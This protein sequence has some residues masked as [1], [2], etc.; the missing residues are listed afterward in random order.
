MKKSWKNRLVAVVMILVSV[1]FAAF[2][3]EVIAVN[4]LIPEKELK[5]LRTYNDFL[6]KPPYVING[7]A[8]PFISRYEQ[9]DS[10]FFRLKRNYSER[11][12]DKI[13]KYVFEFQTNEEGFRDVSFET[14]EFK[15]SKSV[16]LIGDSVTF[17]HGVNQ[18]D[19]FPW[20]LKDLLPRGWTSLNLGVG[21]W[22]PAEYYLAAREYIGKY[23]PEVVVLSYYTSNDFYDIRNSI[24][25]GKEQGALPESVERVNYYFDWAGNFRPKGVFRYPI[26]RNSKL[27]VWLQRRHERQSYSKDVANEEIDMASRMVNDLTTRFPETRFV[28]L[29]FPRHRTAVGSPMEIDHLIMRFRDRFMGG[30]EP[31]PNLYVRDMFPELFMKPS[32]EHYYVDSAHFSRDGNRFVAESISRILSELRWFE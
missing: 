16:M 22:G 18:Q 19:S 1:L 3:A 23:D 29:I 28:V 12:E 14:A 26:V 17:G 27:A 8:T 25:D 7:E 13:N 32:I 20:Q 4:Y 6:E 24:W 5:G 2:L 11:H 30:L 31:A 10:L 15:A 21:G 9:D